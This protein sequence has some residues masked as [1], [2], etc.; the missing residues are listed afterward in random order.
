MAFIPVPK[1][2]VCHVVGELFGQI[3]ENTLYFAFPDDPLTSEIG[4][5][6]A[7][8]GQWA[9]GELCGQLSADYKY[10]R[11]EAQSLASESAPAITDVTGTGT[12][13]SNLEGQSAPGG[14]CLAVSFRSAYGGR[15]Y[16]GRNYVSG[17]PSERIVGNQVDAGYATA[18]VTVYENLMSYIEDD[19]PNAVHVIVSRYT[20]GAPR[21]EGIT[22]PVLTYLTTNRDIDSQRRR[23]TG[24]GN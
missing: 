23:L 5:L 20:A 12:V 8:V 4:Q 16:R 24:R 6:A 11:T 7:S 14:S 3:I 2:A 17:L 10:L 1:T 15:S 22:T 18:L 19:L 21:V 9:V 13:G